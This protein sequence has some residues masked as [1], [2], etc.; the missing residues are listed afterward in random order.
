MTMPCS[1]GFANAAR[2]RPVDCNCS[3]LAAGEHATDGDVLGLDGDKIVDSHVAARSEQAIGLPQP[4]PIQGIANGAR[5]GEVRLMPARLDIGRENVARLCAQPN[6]SDVVAK[7]R[8]SGK[9][10]SGPW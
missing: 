7:M 4:R 5:V 1:G 9:L 10:G 6:S 8:S 2:S 3:R